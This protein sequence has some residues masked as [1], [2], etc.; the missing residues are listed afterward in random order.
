MEQQKEIDANDWVQHSNC[1]GLTHLFFGHPSERPQAAA[2]REA[3][4]S[5]ICQACS[6]FEQCRNYARQ[7]REFGFWAGENE[8][9]R[10]ALGFGPLNS[11]LRSKTLAAYKAKHLNEDSDIGE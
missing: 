4:A 5:L 3:R 11:R 10:A 6:V 1:K 2:R 8:Y 7:N 9:D